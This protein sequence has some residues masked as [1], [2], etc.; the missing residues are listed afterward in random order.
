M[1]SSNSK[2]SVNEECFPKKNID[3]FQNIEPEYNLD[4]TRFLVPILIWGPNNQVRGFMETIF[5]A[6]KEKL[7]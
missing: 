3:A 6:I 2:S 5:L 7:N 4:R 1:T